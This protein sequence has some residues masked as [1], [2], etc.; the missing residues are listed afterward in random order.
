[1]TTVR[2]IIDDSWAG[3]LEAL[4]SVP[5]DRLEEP[6]ACGDWSVKDLMAHMAF[7]DDRAVYVADTI[8]AGEEI[9]P[10][11]WQEANTREATLRANWTLEESRREMLAAHDRVIEALERHP[12]LDA[13]VWEGD[14]FDHYNEHAADIRKWL[15]GS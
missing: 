1:M 6:G 10:I 15:S 9:E 3:F 13:S 2:Q 11:D 4:E 7:W 5:G 12:E 8:G 14:T